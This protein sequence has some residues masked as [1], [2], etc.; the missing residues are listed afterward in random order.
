M[1]RM[2]FGLG[3]GRCGTMSLARILDSCKEACITHEG[4][5]LTPHA[6][7]LLPWVVDEGLL[8]SNVKELR[9][10]D[11]PIV[12]DVGFYY[13]PYVDLILSRYPDSK[14]IS[15]QRDKEGTVESY[16]RK[17]VGRN[18]WQPIGR[19]SNWRRD[20]KWDPC[21]PKYDSTTKYKALEKYWEEYYKTCKA[22]SLKYPDNIR[23]FPMEDLN[24]TRGLKRIAAFVGIKGMSLL[25]KKVYNRDRSLDKVR[26]KVKVD[27]LK[28]RSLRPKGLDGSGN[29]VK[30]PVNKKITVRKRVINRRFKK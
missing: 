6:N 24:S 28:A 23:V 9:E 2:L 15:V 13:L 26:S 21:Y 4:R 20:P 22:L 17:T 29:S 12:G 18:H 30:K 3:T 8:W 5:V 16:M 25:N 19:G 27:A 14:F 7:G 1:K 11:Y 10:K